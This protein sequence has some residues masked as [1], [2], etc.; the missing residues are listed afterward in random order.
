MNTKVIF[1]LVLFLTIV[2]SSSVMA[3]TNLSFGS[4][5]V[6]H[7]D[8]LQ[9]GDSIHFSFWLI[10]DGNANIND[11][12]SML[13]ETFDV[14]GNSISSMSIGDSYNTVGSLNV[15]DSIFVTITEE[16]TFSSYVLGDNI[17]VIW[18]AFIGSGSIDTSMTNVHVLGSVTGYSE[19]E[20]SSDKLRIFPNPVSR[21]IYVNT[22]II[23]NCGHHIPV[24]ASSLALNYIKK[25]LFL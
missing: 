16:V 6:Q 25:N 12:I 17:V 4:S 20:F 22:Q 5:G 15:G 1:F 21:D 8:T 13:C 7:E 2:K 10:N 14:I 11:S 18:P 19:L 3:Q 23:K 24:E 9:I